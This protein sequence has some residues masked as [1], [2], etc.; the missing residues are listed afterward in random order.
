MFENKNS[1]LSAA[2]VLGQT[3]LSWLLAGILAGMLRPSLFG[4]IGAG[5]SLTLGL[6]R[7]TCIIIAV[8]FSWIAHVKQDYHCALYAGIAYIA[9]IIFNPFKI[10]M[11]LIQMILCF[12]AHSQMKKASMAEFIEQVKG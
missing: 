11:V 10:F 6:P 2:T 9:V 3:Y 1:C 7:L 8:V 12:V 4:T 5:L